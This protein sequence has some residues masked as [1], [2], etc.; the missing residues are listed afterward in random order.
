MEVCVRCGRERVEWNVHLPHF[1]ARPKRDASIWTISSETVYGRS[2][3]EESPQQ[4][5]ASETY[6]T[7][8]LPPQE[9]CNF[10]PVCLCWREGAPQQIKHDL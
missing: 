3:Y 7:T 10:P 4:A 8:L 2:D 1:N 6:S 9:S 5:H